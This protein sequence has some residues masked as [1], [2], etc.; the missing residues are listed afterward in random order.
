MEIQQKKIFA[1]CS[2][3]V[4]SHC[5]F[6]KVFADQF[7]IAKTNNPVH[8]SFAKISSH[9]TYAKFRIAKFTMNSQSQFRNA[10]FHSQCE[11]FAKPISQC[12]NQFRN[13]KFKFAM[14]KFRKANFAMPKPISQC[15]IQI[16]NAKISQCQFRNANFNFAM[17]IHC[18]FVP[19]CAKFRI[20][21]FTTHFANFANPFR[22]AKFTA[23]A[24]FTFAN[25]FSHCQIPCI[26]EIHICRPCHPL[27]LMQ[28]T[29]KLGE[30]LSYPIT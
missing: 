8:C 9:K 13:A 3:T 20:A 28:P 7:R 16:R 26:C 25:P 27:Q 11:N 23:F 24:K 4:R 21:K 19:T 12:Q 10:K 30:L 1:N 29:S 2:Q 22:I 17:P 6:R 18:S 15:Q 14:R 5:E